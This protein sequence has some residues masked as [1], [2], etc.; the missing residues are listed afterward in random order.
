VLF[1]LPRHPGYVLYVMELR[2]LKTRERVAAAHY[3]ER[4][5]PGAAAAPAKA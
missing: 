2:D 5:P 3:F 4:T 1:R